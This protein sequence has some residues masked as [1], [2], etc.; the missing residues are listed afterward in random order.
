[1]SYKKLLWLALTVIAVNEL[2]TTSIVLDRMLLSS[3]CQL[4]HTKL[5]KSAIAVTCSSSNISTL[6]ELDRKV[7]ELNYIRCFVCIIGIRC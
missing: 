1:M 4:C 3:H 2:G 5:S 6:V 7:M